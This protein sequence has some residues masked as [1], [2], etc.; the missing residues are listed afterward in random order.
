MT[1]PTDVA[2]RLRVLGNSA[3]VREAVTALPATDENRDERPHLVAFRLTH[4]EFERLEAKGGVEWIKK[5]L[6]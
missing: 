3:F 1:F 2:A 6:I 4:E 5:L